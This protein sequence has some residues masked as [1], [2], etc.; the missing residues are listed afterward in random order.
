M[1]NHKFITDILNIEESLLEKCDSFSSGD[2][3][4]FIIRLLPHTSSCPQCSASSIVSN[5][6]YKKK[7]NHSTLN[8]RKCTILY[9]ARRYI[10]KNCGL[11]FS[12]SNP[13][14]SPHSNLTTETISNVLIDLKD[15]HSTYT[16]V[17]KKHHIS[18][19]Q[20]INIFDMY[21]D[22]PRK[23]LPTILSIDEF[24]FPNSDYDA[25]YAC[26]LL[27]FQSGTVLD[28]LPDRSKA[29]L[30]HYFQ[31]FDKEELCSVKFVSIDMYEPYKL[32]SQFYFKNAFIGVD[33]FHVIKNI[34]F[35]FNKIRIR[36]RNHSKDDDLIYLL[37][38]FRN[39]LFAKHIN[40]DNKPKYNSKLK[41][42]LNLRQ[43]LNLIFEKAPEMRIAYDLMHNYIY[44]NDNASPDNV[45]AWLEGL[46]NE[47]IESQIP[48]YVSIYKMLQ[49]WKIE[50][51]NSFMHFNGHR[52]SNGP[53]EAKNRQID[54]LK[55]NANG[56]ANF[57]RARNRIMYCL[58]L[59]DNYRLK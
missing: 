56:Y 1:P 58:N 45:H 57:K 49:N 33:S 4:S 8:N 37:S 52:I 7:L 5:G 35:Q 30:H 39:I 41:R 14:A 48:E 19:T 25:S 6:F 20:A 32:I 23:P 24:Y 31:S 50:I 44:F 3:V 17:A 12:E 38:K 27:D 43:I 29:Y 11:S 34:T 18:P 51:I 13:F 47:L 55:F 15:I 59:D 36:I 40:L 2:D 54:I 53:I 10:C 46:I 42:Y 28:V 21:V 9:D 22:I 16:S 26:L